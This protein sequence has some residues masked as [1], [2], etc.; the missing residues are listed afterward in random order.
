VLVYRALLHPPNR[1]G[2]RDASDGHAHPRNAPHRTAALGDAAQYGPRDVHRRQGH[3]HGHAR[4]VPVFQRPPQPD[5]IPRPLEIRPHAAASP[6]RFCVLRMGRRYVFFFPVSRPAKL[7]H[8]AAL[9]REGDM[10]WLKDSE[11]DDKA[12]H[13][14]AAP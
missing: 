12:R 2:K 10:S 3:P 6:G 13:G 14:A 9:L 11:T 5:T 1:M 4:R 8:A 7:N